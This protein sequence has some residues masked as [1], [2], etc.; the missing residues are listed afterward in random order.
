MKKIM[1]GKFGLGFQAF[2]AIIPF[3]KKIV[4]KCKEKFIDVVI[5]LCKVVPRR[6]SNISCLQSSYI[7]WQNM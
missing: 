3:C 4:K 1:L 5:T 2:V 6:R 7:L